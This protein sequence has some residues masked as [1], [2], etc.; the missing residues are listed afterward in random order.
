MNTYRWHTRFM[1]KS[2]SHEHR[3]S[4]GQGNEI[5]AIYLKEKLENLETVSILLLISSTLLDFPGGQRPSHTSLEICVAQCF[6]RPILFINYCNLNK[7]QKT[8]IF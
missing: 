3:T 8:G 7:K 6:T 2:E 1:G 4:E 5:P